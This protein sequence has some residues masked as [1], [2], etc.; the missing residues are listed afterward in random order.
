M[1]SVAH[2]WV[3]FICSDA[4]GRYFVKIES[5]YL[6]DNFNFFGLRAKGREAQQNF[7]CAVDAIRGPY[8]PPERRPEDWPPDIERSAG[9]LYGLLHA[10]FLLTQIAL[11]QMYE[12]YSREEFP[13]CPRACCDGAV[14]LPYGPSEEIGVSVLR[15]FCP[16]CKE[17]YIADD[18]ISESIDGAFFGPSWVHLFVQKYERE[19]KV[20]PRTELK[21]PMIRLFGFRIESED[22]GSDGD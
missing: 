10:R 4:R 21:K 5:S 17:V 13:R 7:R 18:R 2:S 3:D 16:R 11:S 12:K 1:S 22:D 14:C 8:L 19:T 20:V 15:M 9:R 6:N